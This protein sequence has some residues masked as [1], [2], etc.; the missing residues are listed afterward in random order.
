MPQSIQDL[1]HADLLKTVEGALAKLGYTIAEDPASVTDKT[2]LVVFDQDAMLAW[3]PPPPSDK[4]VIPPIT[5]ILQPGVER[6][7]ETERKV[8]NADRWEQDVVLGF[9]LAGSPGQPQPPS[10]VYQTLSDFSKLVKKSLIRALREDRYRDGKAIDTRGFSAVPW[11][12]GDGSGC[13][14]T[15]GFLI[16]WQTNYN[17]P[18]KQ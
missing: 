3:P 1:I 10:E 17:E 13:G 8:S 11:S 6:E 9:T 14:Y 16:I 4:S 12:W 7:H 5:V 2:A 15:I 18:D